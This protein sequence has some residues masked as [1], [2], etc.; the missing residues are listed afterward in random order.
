MR[1]AAFVGIVFVMGACATVEPLAPDPYLTADA[2]PTKHTEAPAVAAVGD[3]IVVCGE[4]F[5]VGTPVVLWTDPGGYSAYDVNVQEG[6]DPAYR[7]EESGRRYRPGRRAQEIQGT[8]PVSG[9]SENVEDLAQAV[10]QFVVH[11][12]VCGISRNCFKV[13]HHYRGL[14]VHFMLDIDGT[15][16]QTLDL[17]ETTW[18]ATKA[19]DRSIGIE[20]AQIGAY[21]PSKLQPLA[22]W[23]SED[24]GGTYIDIPERY[25]DG[26]VRTQPFRGRPARLGMLEGRINGS[27]L[28]QYDFTPEQYAA[29]EKLLTTLVDVL[30]RI[31]L[32]VP[33]D[34]AG[35]VLA[36][37]MSEPEFEAFS[38]ILGHYHVQENK[39]DPGPAFDWERLMRGLQLR[40]LQ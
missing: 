9:L 20:I 15:I 10:D 39:T 29:L 28:L 33:R 14:S 23:Y 25:G 31:E 17:R 32:R 38:G 3:E 36:N 13:L 24:E 22:E 12:D 34:G 2:K 16:Y 27:R 40:L 8:Q 21:L 1:W 19:N 35:E 37:Q 5:K 11:F 6:T 26:G 4:R 30:P 7:D 18:H